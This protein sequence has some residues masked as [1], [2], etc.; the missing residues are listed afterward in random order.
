M[1]TTITRRDAIVATAKVGAAVSLSQAITQPV[2]TT[3]QAQE[4][5]KPKDTNGETVRHSA[6][7]V[8]CGSRCP[9]K[10]IGKKDRSVR[11]EPDDA[12]DDAVFGA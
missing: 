8:T 7:L 3:A 6:C 5:T 2:T 1:N 10:V 11:I 4:T 9:L 12:K